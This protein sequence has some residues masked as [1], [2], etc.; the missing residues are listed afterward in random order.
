MLKR[1][2]PAA[3]LAITAACVPDAPTRPMIEEP[4]AASALGV[5]ADAATSPATL[6][7]LAAIEDVGSRILPGIE[8]PAAAP[9]TVEI[10]ELAAQL[11]AGNAGEAGLALSRAQSA[12]DRVVGAAE[13]AEADFIR[14]VLDQARRH[15]EG[16]ALD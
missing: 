15:L 14:L 4:S 7:L 5:A 6:D 16:P 13:A 9:L 3:V 1:L 2:A 12:L 11:G 8:D 10:G